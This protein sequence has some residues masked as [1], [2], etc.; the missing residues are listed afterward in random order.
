[1]LYLIGSV[2]VLIDLLL[3]PRCR[4]WEEVLTFVHDEILAARVDDVV[5]LLLATRGGEGLFGLQI[6]YIGIMRLCL[7]ARLICQLLPLVLLDREELAAFLDVVWQPWVVVH[8]VLGVHE[9]LVQ[10]RLVEDWLLDFSEVAATLAVLRGR[11]R[12]L[13]HRLQ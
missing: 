2:G 5:G 13:A 8:R 12:Q 9:I 4:F 3:G 11:S 6:L 7:V 10:S 1:M